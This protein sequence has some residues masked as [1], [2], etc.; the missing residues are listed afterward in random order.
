MGK[1]TLNSD[2][3]NKLAKNNA[4]EIKRL[5][6]MEEN[7]LTYSHT[8]GETPI[9]PDYDFL[10]VQ[11]QLSRLNKKQAILRG[12]IARFN[13][14]TEITVG[15]DTIA[16]DQALAEIKYLTNRKSKLNDMLQVP[17]T[18]RISGFQRKEPEIVH[19]NFNK[20]NVQK[21]YDETTDRLL[22]L[23]QAVNIANLTETF[24]VDLDSI[25]K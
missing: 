14:N 3:A 11:R 2:T 24:E 19:R 22:A 18:S 8:P 12:A 6:L 23:Q 9:V 17:E 15:E 7:S 1:L 20:E 25:R 21:T 5:E 13:M 10:E 4:A 16:I